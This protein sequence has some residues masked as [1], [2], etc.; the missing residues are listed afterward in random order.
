MTD[1][2]SE[3]KEKKTPKGAFNKAISFLAHLQNIEILCDNAA[4]N[5]EFQEWFHGLRTWLN[6]LSGKLSEERINEMKKEFQK[7]EKPVYDDAFPDDLKKIMLTTVQIKIEK[8]MDEFNYQMPE[9]N[10]D[11]E[12]EDPDFT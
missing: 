5:N 6:K 4:I 2:E 8:I 12:E 3:S 7:I 1:E 9:L 11:E 10:S